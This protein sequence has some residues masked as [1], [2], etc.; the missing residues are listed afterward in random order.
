MP[1][2]L[3]EE[4][5]TVEYLSYV[6]AGCVAATAGGF[7]ER[8]DKPTVLDEFATYHARLCT[9]CGACTLYRNRCFSKT[10]NPC[11]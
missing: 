9:R 11:N 10:L 5:K 1:E 6:P 7:P 8:W 3:S 2:T 4:S